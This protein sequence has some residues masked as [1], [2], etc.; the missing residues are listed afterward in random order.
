MNLAILLAAG[1]GSRMQGC[2]DD[3]V[4]AILRDKPVLQ[5]SLEAFAASGVAN[6]YCIVC[7]NQQQQAAIEQLVDNIEI[8]S[9]TI[10]Y[11]IGG[12][13]RSDSVM[14]ALQSVSESCNFVFIHDAARPMVSS[15]S[16]LKL[17]AAVQQDQA[18]VLAHPV[19]DTIKRIPSSASLSRIEFEDLERNRLWAMETPQAFAFEP[20]RSAYQT[21]ADENLAITDDCAAASLAGLQIS[22]VPNDS[23]NPKLT[24]AADLDYLNWLFSR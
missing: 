5:H 4:L 11:C 21:I 14:N 17:Y 3:K 19:T 10:S 15:S 6:R 23:P 2:V 13:E 9:A 1:S 12:T 7:R 18:A 20:I 22:I 24:T 16:I 8:D